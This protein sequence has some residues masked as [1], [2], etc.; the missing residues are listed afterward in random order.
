MTEDDFERERR[1]EERARRD[2]LHDLESLGRRE[3][4][5]HDHVT[6]V[7]VRLPDNDGD[8]LG[9][10]ALDVCNSVS[11]EDIAPGVIR[12]VGIARDGQWVVWYPPC[13][14][15]PVS[16]SPEQRGGRN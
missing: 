6:V 12:H 1:E 3:P 5:V 14:P 16:G 15:E 13:P 8:D 4:K 9:P 11:V 10:R 2:A 7:R